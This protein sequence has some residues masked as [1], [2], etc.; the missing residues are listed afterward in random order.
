VSRTINI[1][2]EALANKIA[3]GEVVQRPASAVKELIENSI[4]SGAKSLTVIVKEGG[5]KLIQVVDDGCGMSPE[6]A[7]LAFERHSTSKIAVLEDL[8]N[9]RTL[10]FRGEAL[11]SIAAV[12]Q[13]EL[14]TRP[15][16]SD[17]GTKVR[18]DGGLKIEISEE[19][20]SPGSAITVKN[21]FYNT[22]ARR[23]FLKS[24]NTEFKHIYDVVQRVALSFPQLEI[25]FV[26]EDDTLLH[27]RPSTLDERVREVFGEKLWKTIFH[28]EEV[29]EAVTVSGFLGKPDFARKTHV[30]QYLYLNSRFVINR[31]LNRAV[32]QAYEHLLEKGS[33]PFFVLFLSVDPRKVDVNVHPSKMEVKFEDES[34]MYRLVLSAVRTALASQDLTPAMGARDGG[35]DVRLRFTP[36]AGG[37]QPRAAHWEELFGVNKATGEIPPKPA[38]FPVQAPAGCIDEAFRSTAQA[39]EPVTRAELPAATTAAHTWQIHN[40]YI[41]VPIEI[42]LLIVDQHAAHERVIYERAVAR[43]DQPNKKSQQLLFPQ[44]I[45]MTPGDAA[46]VLQL[47]SSLE[48]LGFSLKL[49][50]KTTVIIDGVPNDVKPGREASILQDVLDLYK[51]DE[52]SVKLEPRERLAK[53]FSCKAAVKAGDQLNEQE[54]RSLLDQ[55]FATQ[56][57]YVCPHGRPVMIRLSLSELDKRFGRTS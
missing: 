45:E 20:V 17:V 32:Y 41:I 22:P 25:K 43:F 3:A 15:A 34:A 42:G 28:F 6:D 10:G 5:K 1:L 49:F 14:R 52:H 57:P 47:H 56:V 33:F 55:L 31:S 21:L 39:P 2:P 53:S 7:A 16:A 36:F 13:I 50:G 29:M 23:K 24:T 26:N 4:D 12:S 54:M 40:K 19:A 9:I 51:S 30:E 27:V 44:T 11:S 48:S 37:P 18:I 38:P 46:L 8:E 35:G